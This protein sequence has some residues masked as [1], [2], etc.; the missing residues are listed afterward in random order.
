VLK[1][2][3]TKSQRRN[4]RS[5][6]ANEKAKAPGV[7]APG[8]FVMAASTSVASIHPQSIAVKIAQRVAA[9]RPHHDRMKNPLRPT[10]PGYCTWQL[11]Q[12]EPGPL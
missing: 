6:H 3:A 9:M 7:V 5:F 8:A 4:R 12:D 11:I 2:G 1:K 10:A